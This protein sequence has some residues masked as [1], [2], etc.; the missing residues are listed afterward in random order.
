M[1]DSRLISHIE[2]L[3]RLNTL[4]DIKTIDNLISFAS[5]IDDRENRSLI[6]SKI[7]SSLASEGNIDKALEV[8]ASIELSYEKSES[9]QKIANYLISIGHREKALKILQEAQKA[10]EQVD[11]LWQKA[12]L[13]NRIAYC[14]FQSCLPNQAF[15]IWEQAIYTAK[16]GEQSASLQDSVDSSS[17]LREIA[18]TLALTN[19]LEKALEVAE[20]IKSVGK[21]NDAIKYV[22]MKFSNRN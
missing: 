11:E 5:S 18:E 7:A 12:E 19:N 8:T 21:R 13:L 14:Y 3:L 10:I 4:K 22:K 2:S 6:M 16:F 20:S 17:V 1:N 9:L 15:L